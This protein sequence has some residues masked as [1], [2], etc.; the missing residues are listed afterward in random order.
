M[1]TGYSNFKWL[2]FGEVGH[3]H[4]I[5]KFLDDGWLLIGLEHRRTVQPNGEFFDE[6][7]YLLGRKEA[8]KADSLSD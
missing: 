5:N 1:I 3:P 7:R 2:D 6:T 4:D 8:P